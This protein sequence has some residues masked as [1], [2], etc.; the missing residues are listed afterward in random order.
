[1]AKERID[2]L[3][4]KR[5]LAES[6]EKAKAFLM[7]GI[8]LV[9]DEK[10]FKAGQLVDEKVE[11]RVKRS[12]LKYVSRGGLKL[13]KALQT[14]SISVDSKIGLD[15]GASTGGFTDCLLQNGIARVWAVDCGTNQLSWKIRNDPRVISIEKCNIRYADRAVITEAVDIIVMDVSF[16]SLTLVIPVITQFAK[17]MAD[18]VCLIKPQFE[19]GK[20]EVEKGGIIRSEY[21]HQQVIEKIRNCWVENDWT[22]RQ[23][24]DSPILGK[25]GNKEFLCWTQSARERI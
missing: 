11:I 9:N 16:I 5:G 18:A 22:V 7:A 23:I 6:R 4:V 1:M 17:Q 8:V 25:E 13:E 2:S 12:P 10:I 15:V 14:F 21:K 19:V 24:I 20:G 3:L